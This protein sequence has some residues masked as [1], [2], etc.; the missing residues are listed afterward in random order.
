MSLNVCFG[1]FRFV[2]QSVDATFKKKP[3]KGHKDAKQKTFVGYVVPSAQQLWD[4]KKIMQLL[5]CDIDN[6]KVVQ[7]NDFTIVYSRLLVLDFL[8]LEI[9]VVTDASRIVLTSRKIR[10]VKQT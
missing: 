2:L 7:T 8:L 10:R 6:R 4:L 9:K 1:V 5:F 3:P